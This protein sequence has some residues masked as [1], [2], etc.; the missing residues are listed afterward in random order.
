MF[1]AINL[2][3]S[4]LFRVVQECA[5]LTAVQMLQN[6][7]QEQFI[8]LKCIRKL[9]PHTQTHSGMYEP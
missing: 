3:D 7:N 4:V 8:E 1:T 6:Y 2:S 5:I 9:Q